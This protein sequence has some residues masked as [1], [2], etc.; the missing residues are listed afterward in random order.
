MYWYFIYDGDVRTLHFFET[1]LEALAVART[2]NLQSGTF[3]YTV[4]KEVM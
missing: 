4:R 3:R 1:D 2:L